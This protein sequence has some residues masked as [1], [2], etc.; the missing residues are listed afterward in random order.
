MGVNIDYHCVFHN[1]TLSHV[2]V[3]PA[4]APALLP[5]LHYEGPLFEFERVLTPALRHFAVAATPIHEAEL[6]SAVPGHPQS[7]YC[8]L[9]VSHLS[10]ESPLEWMS[11]ADV[12]RCESDDSNQHRALQTY[13]SRLRD[14]H[15]PFDTLEQIRET[16][17]WAEAQLTAHGYQDVRLDSVPRHS[18]QRRVARFRTSSGDI[19]FKAKPRTLEHEIRVTN[20]L[21]RTAPSCYGTTVA[22][23]TIR[24]W[25]LREAVAGRILRQDEMTH[26]AGVCMGYGLAELQRRTLTRTDIAASF[27]QHTFGFGD[28]ER[29]A[30]IA[31]LH[32]HRAAVGRPELSDLLDDALWNQ[33]GA[34][35]ERAAALPS[36]FIHV[37]LGL[38]N[39]L[40]QESSVGLIDLEDALWG[41]APLCLWPLIHDVDIG[42]D[43]QFAASIV[44]GYLAGWRGAPELPQIARSVE[45]LSLTGR[46]M[47]LRR[48]LSPSGGITL[49]FGSNIRRHGIGNRFFTS[50]RACARRSG[51]TTF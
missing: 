47:M 16:E 10:D 43:R 14:P 18:R 20:A 41:P 42:C 35:C 19:Y 29:L 4:A 6:Q 38:P 15:A 44:D 32:V 45:S 34:C 17:C 2:L 12:L 25:W 13:L 50:L 36:S 21:A 31:R 1:E 22:V 48:G 49:S 26:D 11:V 30:M 3:D 7:A 51:A 8:G 37:D 24:A 39:I 27:G 46:L 23:D 28:L 5:I 33:V 40:L 9:I